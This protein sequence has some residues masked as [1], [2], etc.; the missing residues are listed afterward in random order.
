MYAEHPQRADFVRDMIKE[1]KVDGVIG[2]R[3]MFCDQ[4]GIEQFMITKDMKEDAI[5]FLPLDRE[6]ILSGIGQMR[7]RVQAFLETIEG[8]K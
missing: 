2:E 5:P 1:F 4:W 7:T 3:L 8:G 6:Y